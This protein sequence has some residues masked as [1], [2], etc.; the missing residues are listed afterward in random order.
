MIISSARQEAIQTARSLINRKPV[1]L[2]TETTG[3]DNKAEIVEIAIIDH[4]GSVLFESLVKPHFPIPP[5]VERIHHISNEM[6]Y[7]APVWHIVYE[8]VRLLLA[9]KIVGI[10]NVEFDLRLMN[11]TS[12]LYWIK[13]PISVSQCFC[14]MQLYAQ[15]RGEPGKKA[16]QYRYFS[17]ENAGKEARIDLP[18]T[19]RAIDDALLSRALLHHLANQA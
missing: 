18:N 6:V 17:L 5:D 3:L 4:A 14:I 2:D 13:P 12:K 15:Y 10:Y 19:H 8:Q 1:Y 11:Q 9:D 7:Q 16:G